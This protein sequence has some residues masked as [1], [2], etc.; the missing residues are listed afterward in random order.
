MNEFARRRAEVMKKL[1]VNG[2]AVLS[3]SGECQSSR[4]PYRPSSAFYYLTGFAEPDAL[5]VLAPEREDGEYL[6][7]CRPSDPLKEQWEGRRAGLEGARQKFGADEAFPIDQLN[8]ILPKL[9]QSR[10]RLA[11]SFG[12][13]SSFDQRMIGWLASFRGRSRQGIA[14]PQEIIDLDQIISEMRLFKDQQELTMMQ[15]AADISVE[16]HIK[17]MQACRPGMA[18][19]EIEALFWQQFRQRNALPAYRSIIAGG[20]NANILHYTENNQMLRDGDLLLIDA[21][22][23]YQCYAADITRTFPVNGKFSGEQKAIY[24]LVLAAQTEAIEAIKPGNS[25]HLP[26]QRAVELLTR[27]LVDLG[28]LKGDVDNL[29]ELGIQ[30]AQTIAKEPS[31]P[32]NQQGYFPFYMHQTSHWLGLDVHDVGAYKQ[33]GEWRLLEPGMVLTIEPGLYIPSRPEIAERWHTIGV[34]IED[35]ILVTNSSHRNLTVQAPKTV[36]EIESVM[37]DS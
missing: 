16:A 36:A 31:R 23:E 13:E 10:T 3:L 34:R 14:P 6:L 24:E 19:Y 33:S 21:G 12:Q 30:T 20:K 25:Y 17:A 15:I 35:D 37:R 2:V 26:H 5:L 8:E 27:G 28:I 7:F 22:A 32:F 9:L 18:E 1:G 11:Y 29:I 4:M